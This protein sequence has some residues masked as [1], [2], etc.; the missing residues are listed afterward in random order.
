MEGFIQT[1]LSLHLGMPDRVYPPL[2]CT[3]FNGVTGD[4]MDQGK[5]QEGHTDKG[6]KNMK[7]PSKKKLNHDGTTFF[8]FKVT[9]QG[10]PCTA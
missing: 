7:K 6:W 5:G 8:L 10:S 4:E 9:V 3:K 1:H 2:P